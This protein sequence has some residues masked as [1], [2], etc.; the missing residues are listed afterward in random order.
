M[1]RWNMQQKY[2]HLVSK[3]FKLIAES[4]QASC[5]IRIYW[6]WCNE[7]NTREADNLLWLLVILAD[8]Q[9][10]DE[11]ALMW[12]TQ[13]ELATLHSKFYT[14]NRYLVSCITARLF[15]NIGS[16]KIL[17]TKDTQQL[18]LQTWLQPLIEDYY[19]LVGFCRSFDPKVVE[20]GIVRT[21]LSLP[22]EDQESI[23]LV[24]LGYF[25]KS[26]YKDCP[27]LQNAFEVWYRRTLRKL[28]PL[29]FP[30]NLSSF[31]SSPFTVYDLSLLFL[32]VMAMLF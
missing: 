30:L 19:K 15:V 18:L 32:F 1:R 6:K 5:R 10:A 17:T 27:N 9:A 28:S 20:E 4:F 2:I 21:I 3:L 14:S 8:R 24:W 7:T 25:V 13:Q 22:L 23:L 11:F 16:G 29:S 26:G 31:F 12:A